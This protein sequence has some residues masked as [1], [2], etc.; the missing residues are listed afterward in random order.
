MKLS[1]VGWDAPIRDK[2][3]HLIGIA[4]FA[5][6]PSRNFRRKTSAS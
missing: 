1:R 3:H 4:Q 5:Q 6:G 2:T